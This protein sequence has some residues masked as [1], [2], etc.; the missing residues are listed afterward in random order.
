ML[1]RI[2]GIVFMIPFLYFL[3]RQKLRNPKL[4]RHLII[5][6]LLGVLQGFTGWPSNEPNPSF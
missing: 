2:T 5:I 1:G 3:I 6:F 4:K